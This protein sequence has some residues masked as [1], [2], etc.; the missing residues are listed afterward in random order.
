VLD[1]NRDPTGAAASPFAANSREPFPFE[2]EFF[3]GHALL[4]VR[5]AKLADDPH[6]AA[7]F[8]GKQRKMEMQVQGLG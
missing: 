2:N 8:D 6:Y 3:A 1:P 4:L 5:P 7:H